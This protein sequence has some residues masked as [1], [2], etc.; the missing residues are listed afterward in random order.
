MY[1]V[2]VSQNLTGLDVMSADLIGGALISR[3]LT[4]QT[5]RDGTLQLMGQALIS[6][7]LVGWD[8]MS[9]DLIELN[10]TGWDLMGR[11]LMNEFLLVTHTSIPTR[12]RIMGWALISQDHMS[13]DL[14]RRALITEDL[15]SR[16][17]MGG[18]GSYQSELYGLRQTLLVGR[19]GG[20]RSYQSGPYQSDQY[21]GLFRV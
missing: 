7:D 13:Q 1:R 17:L 3:D 2:L 18:S 11:A 19:P 10:V 16:E 15:M 5:L 20:L 21:H 12:A 6:Q 9:R 8:L 4:G 14:M